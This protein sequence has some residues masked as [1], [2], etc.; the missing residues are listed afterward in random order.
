MP[1]VL[2]KR[3]GGCGVCAALRNVRGGAKGTSIYRQ[4][5]GGDVIVV[6]KLKINRRASAASICGEK[7]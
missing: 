3:L 6:M 5:S 2:G 7:A 1:V 4:M